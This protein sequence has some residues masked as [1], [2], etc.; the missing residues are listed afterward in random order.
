[1]QNAKNIK[2]NEGPQ[3]TLW[4]CNVPCIAATLILWLT[5]KTDVLNQTRAMKLGFKAKLPFFLLVAA[6]ITESLVRLICKD[7]HTQKIVPQT[8]EPS[9]CRTTLIFHV[10]MAHMDIDKLQSVCCQRYLRGRQIWWHVVIWSWNTFIM[11]FYHDIIIIMYCIVSFPVIPIPSN[12][13]VYAC[14]VRY[15]TVW[16]ILLLLQTGCFPV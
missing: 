11:A 7:Q 14:L 16:S 3:A 10:M 15:I 9:C 12:H 5:K 2:W 8:Q 4:T 6:S 1:M 13:C